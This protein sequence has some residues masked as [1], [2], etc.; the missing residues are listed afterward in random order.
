MKLGKY[1]GKQMIKY[2]DASHLPLSNKLLY[3]LSTWIRMPIHGPQLQ[4]CGKET[5]RKDHPEPAE[6]MF[7][8]Q[9][10]TLSL[11]DTCEPYCVHTTVL[12]E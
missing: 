12:I 1:K 10:P 8:Y 4:Y 9:S 2:T 11:T 3:I 7:P 6:R 5:Q